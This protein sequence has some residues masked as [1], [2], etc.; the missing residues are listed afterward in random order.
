MEFQGIEMEEHEDRFCVQLKVDNEPWTDLKCF[1][2]GVDFNNEEWLTE[3][4]VF[5]VHDTAES[6]RVRWICEAKKK[7]DVIFDWIELEAHEA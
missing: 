2:S 4:I 3:T 6:I 5:S 7:N 1:M